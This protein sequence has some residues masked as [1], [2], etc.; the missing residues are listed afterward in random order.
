[1]VHVLILDLKTDND[2][3]FFSS[4]TSF[5]N[6]SPKSMTLSVPK[7]TVCIFLLARYLLGQNKKYSS[8]NAGDEKDLQLGGRKFMFL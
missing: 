4:G 7:C 3:A 8:G 1:M 2:E 6:L 5:Y